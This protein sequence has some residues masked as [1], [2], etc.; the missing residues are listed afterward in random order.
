MYM[1][2]YNLSKE[3]HV[4]KNYHVYIYTDAIY[5]VVITFY[6]DVHDSNENG[7]RKM[8]SARFRY[9]NGFEC[10]LTVVLASVFLFTGAHGNPMVCRTTYH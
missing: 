1:F 2:N 5:N 7:Q 6:Y 4:F 8:N 9:S 3:R 10:L